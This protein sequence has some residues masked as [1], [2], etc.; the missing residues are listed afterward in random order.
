MNKGFV[1]IESCDDYEQILG[2]EK[3]DGLPDGGVL[4]WA[5]SNSPMVA[6]PTRAEARA[7]IN[8]TH[9]YVMAFNSL[10]AP[11]KKFCKVAPIN[12]IAGDSKP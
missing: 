8:R 1:V 2:L 5:D 12:I 3:G 6:F 7:A 10:D 4:T 9:H 11:E